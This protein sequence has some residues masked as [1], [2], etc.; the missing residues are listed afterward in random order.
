M[1]FIETADRRFAAVEAVI[2]DDAPGGDLVIVVVAANSEGLGDA[3][4]FGD[5]SG[6]SP[7]CNDKKET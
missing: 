7:E 1:E 4:V 2:F 5:S 3:A 6:V